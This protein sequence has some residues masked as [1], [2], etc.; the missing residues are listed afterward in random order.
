MNS[1]DPVATEA[2][3]VARRAGWKRS[4]L[5]S[6]STG[7]SS[8][9]HEASKQVRTLVVDD[10]PTSVGAI[11]VLLEKEQNIEFVGFARDGEEGVAL[12]EG[13]QPDLILMDLQMPK[14]D[15]LS[16]TRL[17]R[18]SLPDV[19]IIVVTFIHGEE[20]HRACMQG[21]ADGFV[22][23]DRLY[24]D[25]QNE[26]RRVLSEHSSRCDVSAAAC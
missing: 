24:Q 17:I 10:S 15:G 6:S 9:V 14:L 25:L 22:V 20:I 12:A 8:R 23:K 26:I 2:G 4:D 11:R 13:L 7:K 3:Q 1:F 16:A 21:G 18:K 5:N 19:R